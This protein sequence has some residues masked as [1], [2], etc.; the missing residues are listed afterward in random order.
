MDLDNLIR[1]VTL[2][3]RKMYRGDFEIDYHKDSKEFDIYRK[4]TYCDNKFD[5][6]YLLTDDNNLIGREVKI[7][8]QRSKFPDIYSTVDD[9]LFSKSLQ[10]ANLAIQNLDITIGSM[11][12]VKIL[13]VGLEGEA[14]CEIENLKDLD[15]VVVVLPK[16]YQLSKDSLEEGKEFYVIVQNIIQTKTLCKII[17]SRTSELLVQELLYLNLIDNPNTELEIVKVVR[18]PDQCSRVVV[19]NGF[20]EFIDVIPKVKEQINNEGIHIIISDSKTPFLIY[21]SLAEFQKDIVGFKFEIQK[22]NERNDRYD[23]CT[24]YFRN[25]NNLRSKIIG[26]V[27]KKGSIRLNQIRELTGFK[28]EIESSDKYVREEPYF[29]ELAT[30]FGLIKEDGSYV[31]VGSNMDNEIWESYFVGILKYNNIEYISDEL[32]EYK[33]KNL[34]EDFISTLSGFRKVEDILIFKEIFADVYLSE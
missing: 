10:T 27:N 30:L 23:S 13:N 6:F 29:S 18:T 2:Q 33:G 24:V 19:N 8:L 26:S 31:D 34:G 4:F 14:E 20:Q 1:N 3:L 25:F 12:K 16:S 21:N 7:K 11:T 5:N 17:V 15:R 32:R 9:N 22:L 28:I